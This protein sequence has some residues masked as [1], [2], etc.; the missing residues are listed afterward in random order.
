MTDQEIIDLASQ[1]ANLI[2]GDLSNGIYAS[3]KGSLSVAWSP[4]DKF[5]A[6]ADSLGK[7]D[8]PPNHRIVLHYELARQLYRDAEDYHDFCVGD[9]KE[10]AYQSFFD[11][12]DV[13][14]K[15]PE[16]F[17]REAR[18]KNMFI[19]AFT[20]VIFHELGHL[21]QEHRYIRNRFYAS[22]ST[23]SQI[24]EWED[25]NNGAQL[26]GRAAAVFHATEFAADFEGV[27]W[28]LMELMRHFLKLESFA[29]GEEVSDKKTSAEFQ[30]ALFLLMSGIACACYRFY[31]TRPSQP[32]A[33]PVG[34]HPTPIRRLE[35]CVPHAFE[36]L[37]GVNEGT[38]SIHGMDR[39]QVVHL[40]T[41]AGYTAGLFWLWRY[42]NTPGIP[43]H[44]MLKGAIQDPHASTYWKT[45]IET[46]DEIEPAI[47]QVRR[48][49]S[50]LSLL[51]FSDVFRSRVTQ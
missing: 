23:S 15:M 45:I 42:A 32:S 7:V 31:G 13:K 35:V 6:S 8:E 28:C 46:W 2:V 18:I 17:K 47:S 4:V 44:Y 21:T 19:G 26:T 9:F 14:P 38:S 22:V 51:Q 36:M 30:G 34:T 33:E 12:F 41:G 39:R 3:L 10:E 20:W 27:H 5:N 48:F 49:G 25:A 1:V 43:E 24:E 50:W 40:C 11:G 37:S 16:I 29:N